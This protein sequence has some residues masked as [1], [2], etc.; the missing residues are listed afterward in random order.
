MI[1]VFVLSN[2]CYQ[3]AIIIIIIIKII[4]TAQSR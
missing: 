1:F 4:Y 2:K 3:A